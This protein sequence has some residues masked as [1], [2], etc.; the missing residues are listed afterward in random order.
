MDDIARIQRSIENRLDQKLVENKKLAGILGDAPSHY[1][2]SPSL[3]NRAFR[4]LHLDAIYLPFDVDEARL[5]DFLNAVRSSPRVIGINVTVPYKVQV[6]PHLDRVEGKARQIQAVNTI[7]RTHEGQLIGINTDG[8]GFLQS[9]QNPQPGQEKPLAQFLKGMDVLIIG[10]GGSARAVAFS[11]AEILD[12]G[13]LFICNRTREAASSLA[14]EIQRTFSGVQAMGEDDLP[15]WSPKVGLI[16]NCSTKGQG[17]LRK[18]I[19]GKVTILEPYS[20]LAPAHPAAVPES[21]YGAPELYRAWLKASLADIEANNRASWN[22][23]L[24]IPLETGFCDL[25]YFPEETVFLRHG[26]LSGHRTLNGQGM[27]VG[28][29][30]EAFFAVCRDFLDQLGL[31]EGEIRRRIA[32][33][34]VGV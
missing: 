28:Q 1:S 16:V 5:S 4:T 12:H 3:W 29:A 34:M 20:S 24:S 32:A 9:V 13:R 8:V 14:S 26:R 23:T 25:I 31:D 17:G 33:A 22:L 15:V 21:Q 30:V 6:I 2:Q 11:L 19:D 18:T 7:L 10:A 27:I